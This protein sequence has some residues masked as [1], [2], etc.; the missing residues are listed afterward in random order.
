MAHHFL[1]PFPIRFDNFGIVSIQSEELSAMND[2]QKQADGV[3]G[4]YVAQA[5]RAFGYFEAS[6]IDR[7]EA[8]RSPL[9][10]ASEL[11]PNLLISLKLDRDLEVVAPFYRGPT[12]RVEPVEYLFDAEV[13][14][15]IAA[16]RRGEA[17]GGTSSHFALHQLAAESRVEEKKASSPP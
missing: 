8:G 13:R 12:S 4:S 3:A 5:E 10:A 2:I 1:Y 6:V 9:E 16:E 15:A 14:T 7:L 11:H 17:R